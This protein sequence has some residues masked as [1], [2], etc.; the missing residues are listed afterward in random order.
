MRLF[1]SAI[2]V[3]AKGMRVLS[4]NCRQASR[5]QSDALDRPLSTPQHIGLRIHL[6]LCRW[7][8]RYGAQL[9][10][11]RQA[12]RKNPDGGP[13]SSPGSTLPPEARAR[14]KRML[15]DRRGEP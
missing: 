4:P 13:S 2:R 15:G 9:R 1:H 12:S 10:F 6:L 7:C 5:L 8:R 14:M 11:L 3:L